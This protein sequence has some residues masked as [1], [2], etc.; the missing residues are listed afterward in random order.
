MTPEHFEQ[1]LSLVSPTIQKQ[2]TILRDS[3]PARI[4]IQINL[5]FLTTV[6]SYRTLQ[7]FFRL[8]KPAVSQFLPEVCHAIYQA[9]EGYIKVFYFFF[10]IS[11]FSTLPILFLSVYIMLVTVEY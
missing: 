11:I 5:N 1:L 2:D 8:S 3:I 6:N 7:H 4:K 10:T 9:L